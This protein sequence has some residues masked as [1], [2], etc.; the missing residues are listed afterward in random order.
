[1]GSIS[2]AKRWV[3]VNPQYR[4]YQSSSDAIEYWKKR[5][6][7]NGKDAIVGSQTMIRLYQQQGGKCPYCDRAITAEQIQNR[8][9]DKHHQFPRSLG[10]D[11]RLRNLRLLH[12]QCHHELHARFSRKQM[13]EQIHSGIDYLEH[14]YRL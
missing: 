2:C 11:Y 13:T 4:V 7:I 8:E 10:G 12:R 1:M 3:K 14:R 6:Y 5:E 9:V